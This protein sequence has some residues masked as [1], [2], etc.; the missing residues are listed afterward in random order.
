MQRN[1]WH[2]ITSE[3]PPEPGGVS[4]YTYT[5]ASH[6]AIAGDIVHVWCP[7]SDA[8]VQGP[9]GVAVHRRL[10]KIGPK[11]L[12]GCSHL[13]DTFSPPRRLLVQWVPHGYGYHSV[14]LVFA[15]WIWLRAWL[16]RDTVELMMHEPF[17]VFGGSF[18]Q[19][20]AALAQRIMI[21][22]LLNAARK[23]WVAIPAWKRLCYQY[24][25][26]RHSKF[27]WLPLPSN[28]P[29]VEDPQGIVDVRERY[30]NAGSVLLGHFGTYDRLRAEMLVAVLPV[31]LAELPGQSMVLMGRGSDEMR[32]HFLELHPAFKSQL[33]ATGPLEPDVLSRHISAC[34]LFIQLY[35]DGVSTRRTSVMAPLSHGRSIVTTTGHLTE[36]LW[37]E[38]GAVALVPATD[39][40]AIVEM[41]KK[42][43]ANEAER[44][45]LG[46]TAKALYLARFDITLT[47]AALRGSCGT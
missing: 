2:V 41:T 9:S 18:R 42:L 15:S 39:V 40:N 32:N 22:I 27:E 11:D 10:G 24:A 6:L 34:D 13:L 16:H 7:F 36:S 8:D 47:V 29:H 31:L 23:V 46:K 35:P 14:N 3:Y 1:E 19:Y 26:G 45:R 38:S 28:V 21:T 4:D 30:G 5:L 17:L 43:V 20:M 12:Y 37:E 25:L 44:V 33:Y